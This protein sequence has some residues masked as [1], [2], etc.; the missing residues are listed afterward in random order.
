MPGH[1]MTTLDVQ[2]GN[3]PESSFNF[4]GDS[5]AVN[6]LTSTVTSRYAINRNYLNQ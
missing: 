2:F 1:M 6:N 3:W 4:M 5:T